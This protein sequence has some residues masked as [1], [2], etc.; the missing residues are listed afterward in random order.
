MYLHL[1]NPGADADYYLGKLAPFF[2]SLQNSAI[3]HT[4]N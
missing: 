2:L 3:K 1:W 4:E